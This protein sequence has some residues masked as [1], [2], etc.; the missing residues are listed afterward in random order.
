MRLVSFKSG[1]KYQPSDITVDVDRVW[2]V[3]YVGYKET[4]LKI[5]TDTEISVWEPY[6]EV[7]KKW[8]DAK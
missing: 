2:G 6:D 7:V 5:G 4:I 8:R 1:Y 3:L